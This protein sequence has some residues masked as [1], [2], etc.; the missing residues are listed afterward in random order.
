M[1]AKREAFTHRGYQFLPD[2]YG[3]HCYSLGN[4]CCIA[5]WEHGF[6]AY[7]GNDDVV[8]PD[9]AHYMAREPMIFGTYVE[10]ADA[11]VNIWGSR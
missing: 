4:G 6:K 1:A 8:S 11:C 5:P 2:S 9:A 10:A 7:R 3:W